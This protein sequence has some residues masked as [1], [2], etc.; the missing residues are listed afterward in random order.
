M[1]ATIAGKLRA[2]FDQSMTEIVKFVTSHDLFNL[3]QDTAR[4]KLII[5]VRTLPEYEDKCVRNALHVQFNKELITGESLL[6]TTC[7]KLAW[8]EQ[9]IDCKLK[10]VS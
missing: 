7:T 8:D 5:D 2:Q 3:L 1:Q 4:T 6:T 9:P 10:E